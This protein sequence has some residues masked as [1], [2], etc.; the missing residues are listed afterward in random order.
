MQRSKGSNVSSFQFVEKITFFSGQNFIYPVDNRVLPCLISYSKDNW[1]TKKLNQSK[2]KSLS[3]NS[4]RLNQIP[5]R[6]WLCQKKWN[7][8]RTRSSRTS[9]NKSAEKKP[10]CWPYQ[11]NDLPVL[12]KNHRHA[13]FIW[14]PEQKQPAYWTFLFHLDALEFFVLVATR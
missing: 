12:T 10:D 5:I 7:F 9:A 14:E 1:I 2:Q 4:P 8:S 3:I 13:E 6:W 11:F